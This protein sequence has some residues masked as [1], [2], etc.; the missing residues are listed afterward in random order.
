MKSL[1]WDELANIYDKETGQT[2]R[3]KPMESIYKW[4]VKRKDLFT[5][6]DDSSLSLKRSN[7]TKE[8]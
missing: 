6:N 1:T 7:V 8:E 3:I 4:A 2:A 5:V